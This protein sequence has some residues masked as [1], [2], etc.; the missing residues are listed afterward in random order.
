MAD[1]NKKNTFVKLQITNSLLDLLK[2]KE[3]KSIS[4]SDLTSQAKVSRVSFYRNYNEKE[5]I[6]KEYVY[7]L[8]GDWHEEY[9]ESIKASE[10]DMLGS[11]FDHFSKQREFYLLLTQRNLFH[12]LKDVLKALYGP[13]PEY[14]NFG[15]YV[16]AYFAYGLFG[17]I[18]EWF[19]RGMQES[20]EEMTIL[21]KNRDLS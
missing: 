1:K 3:L 13:K 4:I 21:L 20:A 8:I 2:I 19:A 17:W 15:A 5:D 18:E 14:P 7:K 6:I 12:L 10:E 9:Q 11:M 16:A